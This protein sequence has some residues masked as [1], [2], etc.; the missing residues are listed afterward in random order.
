MRNCRRIDEKS[1]IKNRS[2]R[3]SRFF[4]PTGR[5]RRALVTK[6]AMRSREEF[7]FENLLTYLQF[8]SLRTNRLQRG[9]SILLAS[10]S[11]KEPGVASVVVH[12]A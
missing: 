4:M 5:V 9:S 3:S 7:L 11:S 8:K 6:L 12:A 1:L 10:R 2:A